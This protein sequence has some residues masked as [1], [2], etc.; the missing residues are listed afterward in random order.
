LLVLFLPAKNNSAG[1]ES[2]P[3]AAMGKTC[4]EVKTG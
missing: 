1:S 2:L 4:G 3:A